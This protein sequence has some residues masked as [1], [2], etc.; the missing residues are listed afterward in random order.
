METCTIL[1]YDQNWECCTSVPVIWQIFECTSVLRVGKD[2]HNPQIWAH[3][4]SVLWFEHMMSNII[5]KRQDSLIPMPTR[6]LHPWDSVDWSPRS[7]HLNGF[8]AILIRKTWNHTWQGVWSLNLWTQYSTCLVQSKTPLH[9]RG[10][11]SCCIKSG[12]Y[13]QSAE[14]W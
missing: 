2:R 13:N 6:N 4:Y 7:S 11:G 3:K 12:C 14:C 1:G 8:V 5:D 9:P 10:M